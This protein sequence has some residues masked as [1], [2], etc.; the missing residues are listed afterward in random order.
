LTKT[1]VDDVVAWLKR[2]AKPSVRA[3]MA[4]YALPADKALGIAVGDL[5][6]FAKTKGRNHDLALG[7]WAT[8]IYEARMLA[9]FIDDP[10]LVTPA[11]MDAWARDFDSW[12]ICDTACFH[13]FDKTPHAWKKIDLWSSRKSEFVK[14]GSFALLASVALHDKKAP[15]EP[16]LKGLKLIEREATDARNFVWKA[17]NWALRGIGKRN[18]ALRKASIAV[19]Q[20]LADSDDQPSRWVGKDALRKL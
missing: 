11:Q 16:F 2:N 10:A 1:E 7:L 12:G 3:G 18:P 14:R 4:R 6:K 19:A 20:R 9:T 17:V 15:D 8:D 5:R 13:L